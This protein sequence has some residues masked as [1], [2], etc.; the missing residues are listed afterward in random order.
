VDAYKTE[1]EKQLFLDWVLT[2]K[3]YGTPNFW[4]EI[5]KKAEYKGDFYW[6]FAR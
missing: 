2:A 1:A 6:F 5:F 4:E 3:T